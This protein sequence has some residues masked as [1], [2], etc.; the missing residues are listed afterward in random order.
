MLSAFFFFLINSVFVAFNALCLLCL[1]KRPLYFSYL[2]T[3]QRFSPHVCHWGLHAVTKPLL[4][5]KRVETGQQFSLEKRQMI[6]PSRIEV[7][8]IAILGRDWDSFWQEPTPIFRLK[9]FVP[10]S[11]S[12]VSSP[13]DTSLGK[14]PLLNVWGWWRSCDLL[15]GS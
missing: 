9:T 4:S 10:P 5:H 1:D 15:C 2:D 8:A 6:M 13:A 14:H 12:L 7:L 11:K 3:E